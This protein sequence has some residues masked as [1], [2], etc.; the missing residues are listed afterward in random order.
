MLT[1][2]SQCSWPW[3]F[4]FKFIVTDRQWVL[5]AVPPHFCRAF[6]LSPISYPA[7]SLQMP[8]AC[9]PFFTL[10]FLALFPASR[11]KYKW[12]QENFH[13]FS[14]P[15]PRTS[16]QLAHI[17]CLRPGTKDELRLSISS[18]NHSHLLREITTPAPPSLF[19]RVAVSLS[20]ESSLPML[21]SPS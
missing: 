15:Q 12:P 11:R 9:Y 20:T 19:S 4:H 16:G 3:R 5:C 14:S 2:H 13:K 8:Y 7:L 6:L 1:P 17:A 10:K 21:L 18:N